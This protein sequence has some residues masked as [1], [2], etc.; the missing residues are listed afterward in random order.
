[1]VLGAAQKGSEH[2]KDQNPAWAQRGRERGNV[3]VIS[4]ELVRPDRRRLGW[5]INDQESDCG[6]RRASRP[7]PPPFPPHW[8]SESKQE[9]RKRR[10]VPTEEV[11]P[12]GWPSFMS[13]SFP[14]ARQRSAVWTKGQLGEQSRLNVQD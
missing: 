9:T 5:R 13:R 3:D 6:P 12:R 14:E 1:M 8:T 10:P 4:R 2:G 11:R 7:F